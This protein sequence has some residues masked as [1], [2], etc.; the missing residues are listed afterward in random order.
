MMFSLKSVPKD[1]I[2]YAALLSRVIGK[3]DT[4][5]Y[6][7]E[8]MPSEINMYTGGIYGNCGYF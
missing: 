1:M 2:S 7:Y 5:E 6:S 8:E 3:L 4:K